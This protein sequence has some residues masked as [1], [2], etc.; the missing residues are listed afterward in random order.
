M[1][2]FIR[3]ALDGP[4][5]NSYLAPQ[6]NKLHHFKP[7]AHRRSD[8]RCLISIDKWPVPDK[9]DFVR[10]EPSSPLYNLPETESDGSKENHGIVGEET[11][12]GEIARLESGVAIDKDDHDF[13]AKG[14]PG[15]VRLEITTVGKS[16]A[17][18]TLGLAGFVE[19]EIGTAHDN[20][21]DQPSSSD[22]VDKPSQHLG[23][24]VR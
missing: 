8:E 13:E 1:G 2:T 23:R 18:K 11:L 14:K 4:L 12:D 17:I 5:V 7:E 21:V 3:V 6:A 16:F 24:I 10:P 19:G 22:N 9:I 20:E 15:S